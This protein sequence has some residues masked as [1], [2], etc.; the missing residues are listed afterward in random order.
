[1]FTNVQPAL[2][3]A[4][5]L[6]QRFR[7]LVV[8]MVDA[9]GNTGAAGR[10]HQRGG[11]VDRPVGLGLVCALGAAGDVDRAAVA[12]Q[13]MGDPASGTTTGAGDDRDR[14]VYQPR[15]FHSAR[16]GRSVPSMVSSPWPG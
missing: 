11:L 3:P 15:S 6:E 8:G 13:R 4:D 16:C 1:M 2:F 9:D 14:R 12:A 10:R 7:L 5:T